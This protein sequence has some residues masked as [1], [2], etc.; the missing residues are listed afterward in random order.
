VQQGHHNM[1][2][3]PIPVQHGHQLMQQ[4]ENVIHVPEVPADMV[5]ISP[6]RL[7]VN[8]IIQ[9]VPFHAGFHPHNAVI[10]DSPLQAY[11]DTISDSGSDMMLQRI[12]I[13]LGS[14]YQANEAML[15]RDSLIK[16]TVS[17][18]LLPNVHLDNSFFMNASCIFSA[19]DMYELF[20]EG[21]IS[22][23]RKSKTRK[24]SSLQ[25]SAMFSD[26]R[27]VF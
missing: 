18:L 16:S 14:F 13:P 19:A 24:L 5:H 15:A 22:A 27:I 1:Q 23:Q 17:C 9:G 8:T 10:A 3:N 2:Q 26:D 21:M 4:I 25:E 20:G 12:I 11:D 6:P 7:T